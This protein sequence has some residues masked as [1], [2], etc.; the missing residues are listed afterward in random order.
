MRKI[1]T[2]AEAYH[3]PLAPHCTTSPLGATASLSVGA[4][5]PFL[6]IHETAPGALQWGE[7]FMNRPWTVDDKTGYATLPEGPGLGVQIDIAKLQKL[8]AD[9]NYKW[10]FPRVTL[11]DGSVADY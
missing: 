3:V 10:K 8:A 9:P 5:I 7:Q 4:S 11:P 1:A 6:L 2:L